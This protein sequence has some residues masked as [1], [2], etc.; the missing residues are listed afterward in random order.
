M[1]IYIRFYHEPIFLFVLHLFYLLFNIQSLIICLNSIGFFSKDE[2]V[3]PNFSPKASLSKKL[4]QVK[5]SV[6][7][8][9]KLSNVN[10]Q[11]EQ[12]RRL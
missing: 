7:K 12:I 3:F 2:K 11:I 1:N 8:S 4:G 6:P 9:A 5:P 10:R